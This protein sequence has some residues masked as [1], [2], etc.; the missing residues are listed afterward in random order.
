[1]TPFTYASEGEVV[2]ESVEAPAQEAVAEEPVD[3]VVS[4]E[5]DAAVLDND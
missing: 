2:S 5:T 4:E 3:E 1:M